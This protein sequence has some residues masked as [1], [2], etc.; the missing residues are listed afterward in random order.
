MFTSRLNLE[1]EDYDGPSF[2][3]EK[4]AMLPSS[5]EKDA[6][7][8]TSQRALLNY[9]LV[10]CNIFLLFFSVALFAIADQKQ[11]GMMGQNAHLKA[12]N[13]YYPV[14]I[15]AEEVVTLSKDPATAA[16]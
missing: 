8:K 10:S 16:H 9:V 11:R 6:S 7:A 15:T 3:D 5:I 13:S 14:A 1:A 12:V 4:Q 2:D